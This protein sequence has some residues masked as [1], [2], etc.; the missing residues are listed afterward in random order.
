MEYF[1]LTKEQAK[2]T[3]MYGKV[4]IRFLHKFDVTVIHS[5]L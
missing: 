1:R 3:G 2:E 4:Y 5:A